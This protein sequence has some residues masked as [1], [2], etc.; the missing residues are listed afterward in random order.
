M[1]RKN[2]MK[3]LALFLALC[4]LV[5]EKK[6]DD[7]HLGKWLFNALL[8]TLGN[9]G[10]SITQRYQQMAFQYQHKNML[11]FFGCFFAACFC[12][13]FALGENKKNWKK[14]TKQSWM[15]PVL[16]GSSSARSVILYT[17]GSSGIILSPYTALITS[18]SG[19]ISRFLY[20]S[21]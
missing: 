21:I 13:L 8:I 18:W 10:C 17:S 9:A 5:K 4:L 20:F 6:T 3:K 11:M 15:F 19:S 16:S 1:W 12:L 2:D 14:A 7:H